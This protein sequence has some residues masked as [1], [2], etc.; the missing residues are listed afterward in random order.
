MRRRPSSTRCVTAAYAPD[1]VSVQTYDVRSAPDDS[2]RRSSRT[3][4]NGVSATLARCA[5]RSG[6]RCRLG[7][8]NRPSTPEVSRRR[9]SANPRSM[10]EYEQATPT[11]ALCR[12]A[13]SSSP[14]TTWGVGEDSRGKQTRIEQ[15]HRDT[16]GA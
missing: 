7:T 5:A 14:A 15:R 3:Y 2:G 1:L 11:V 10:L 8:N 16:E 6:V 12:E 9:S 4:G 13:D